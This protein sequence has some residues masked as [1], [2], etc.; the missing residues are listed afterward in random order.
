MHTVALSRGRATGAA[1]T[2]DDL[3]PGDYPVT[4]EVLLGE[5][6]IG[7]AK[8]TLTVKDPRP[9]VKPVARLDLR[10]E[11]RKVLPGQSYYAGVTTENVEPGTVVTVKDPG[12]RHHRIRLDHWG[13]ARVRLTVPR[14]TDPGRYRVVA[15][16]PGGRPTP[17]R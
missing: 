6:I 13:S 5:K 9:V 3:K 15:Y 2:W 11:P 4:V 8:R 14:D 7:T 17:R 16:L 1:A 12:G 10:L